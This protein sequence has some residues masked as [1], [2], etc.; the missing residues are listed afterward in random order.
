MFTIIHIISNKSVENSTIL[1]YLVWQGCFVIFYHSSTA[2][3]SL[4]Q[5]MPRST[6]SD[7]KS[8]TLRVINSATV[9]LSD[10][11]SFWPCLPKNNSKGLGCH[12]LKKII[13]ETI[14]YFTSSTKAVTMQ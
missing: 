7:M 6:W 10:L 5:Q 8:C 3:C 4:L 9:G 12:S 14:N 1:C 2:C 13:P 11:S